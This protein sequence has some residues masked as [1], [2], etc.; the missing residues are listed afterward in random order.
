[1]ESD[2][3]ASV[4]AHDVSVVRPAQK[5]T[6]T[7]LYLIHHDPGSHT[8]KHVSS[9]STPVAMVNGSSQSSQCLGHRHNHDFSRRHSTQT[10]RSA[11]PFRAR[12]SLS[13]KRLGPPSDRVSG[14]MRGCFPMYGLW[15]RVPFQR[16]R[17][18]R[19]GMSSILSQVVVD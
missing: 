1:M 10:P 12:R 14:P 7:E 6:S 19:N 11:V 17:I 4:T 16:F 2:A 15:E 13:S 8:P 3:L 5:V 9:S 18:S